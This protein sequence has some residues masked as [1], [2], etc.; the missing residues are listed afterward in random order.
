MSFRAKFE[1]ILKKNNVEFR[2]GLSG[3]GDQTQQPYFNH[4]LVSK[5]K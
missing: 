4:F 1:K 3:G 5:K 2:R